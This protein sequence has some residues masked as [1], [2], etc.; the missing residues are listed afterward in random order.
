MAGPV[1]SASTW[2]SPPPPERLHGI[3]APCEGSFGLR[4]V[5]RIIASSPCCHH[6]ARLKS[7]SAA[8]AHLSLALVLC[9]VEIIGYSLRSFTRASS[10]VNC[11]CALACRSF[12]WRFHAWTLLISVAFAA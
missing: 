4:R 5:R 7:S 10:V 12:R 6:E 8:R 9:H 3:L 2:A 11:Q 1:T